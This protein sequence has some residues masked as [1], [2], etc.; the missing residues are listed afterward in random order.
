M[1]YD[2]YFDAIWG[3]FGRTPDSHIGE[4]DAVYVSYTYS[5]YRLDSV[6]VNST[7]DCYQKAGTVNGATPLPPELDADEILIGNIFFE[8]NRQRIS[9]E[10]LFP[11]I[12]TYSVPKV[13]K[14]FIEK[15]L[16]KT[17]AKLRAGDPVKIL[18]WGG[19][20]HRLQFY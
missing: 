2:Y 10:M 8:R 5:P 13:E 1:A 19:Q 9:D 15:A 12:N 7:G 6:V 11:F 4:E 3:A 16:A 20:C 17:L 18:A 14:T